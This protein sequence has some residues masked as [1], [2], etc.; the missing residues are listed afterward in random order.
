M[1][2]GEIIPDDFCQMS[3][4]LVAEMVSFLSDELVVRLIPVPAAIVILSPEDPASISL[5][6]ETAKVLKALADETVLLI[7]VPEMEMPD[8]AVRATMPD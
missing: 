8:P 6:P 7:V 5:W 1:E 2:R 3:L 4:T